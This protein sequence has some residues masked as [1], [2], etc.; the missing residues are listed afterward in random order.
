MNYSKSHNDLVIPKS[1]YL[2][3]NTYIVTF[4][5]DLL[6]LGKLLFEIFCTERNDLSKEFWSNMYGNLNILNKVILATLWNFHNPAGNW[7]SR[8]IEWSSE[9]WEIVQSIVYLNDSSRWA[10][11]FKMQL[12]LS[13]CFFQ[14]STYKVLVSCLFQLSGYSQP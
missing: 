4:Q 1:I 7:W 14:T 2:S 5:Q 13:I 10:S 9:L 3:Y 12:T 8:S 11:K 6:I